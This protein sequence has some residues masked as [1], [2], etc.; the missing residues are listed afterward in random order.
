MSPDQKGM[1]VWLGI[2]QD[3]GFT[4]R[5]RNVFC[6]DRVPERAKGRG[7]SVQGRMKGTPLW[8]CRDRQEVAC[9]LGA[10]VAHRMSAW[11]IPRATSLGDPVLYPGTHQTKDGK[12]R[13]VPRLAHKGNSIRG[14]TRTCN[15]LIRGQALFH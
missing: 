14:R 4:S 7:R 12:T 1:S 2:I 13:A 8:L 15:R 11:A 9:L 3:V 6:K 5:W 10:R